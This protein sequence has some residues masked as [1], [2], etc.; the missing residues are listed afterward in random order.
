MLQILHYNELPTY[1][2]VG[3][4]ASGYVALDLVAGYN[5]GAFVAYRCRPKG[6]ALQIPNS[7]GIKLDLLS[8]S[9]RRA[10]VRRSLFGRWIF[11][12][13]QLRDIVFG[14]LPLS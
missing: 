3:Y 13:L 11:L 2:R 7:L 1:L 9:R 6:D 8:L 10:P 12:V 5:Q 4:A 14:H